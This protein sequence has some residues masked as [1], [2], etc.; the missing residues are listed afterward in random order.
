VEIVLH[1]A[2]GGGYWAE[3]PALLGC[4]SEGDSVDEAVANIR[5]AS[6]A[7]LEVADQ[8][9]TIASTTEPPAQAAEIEVRSRCSGARLCRILE[10]HGWELRR[11]RGSHHV[12]VQAGNSAILM[13]PVHGNRDLKLGTLRRLLKD[14]GLTA[15]DLL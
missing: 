12:Y 9:M 10:K 3:A 4:V 11:V 14:A 2:E 1:P 6:Q 13:V 7:W 5:E 15:D 8:R